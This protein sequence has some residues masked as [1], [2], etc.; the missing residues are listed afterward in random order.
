MTHLLTATDITIERL[1]EHTRE[2]AI[3]LTEINEEALKALLSLVHALLTVGLRFLLFLL[4]WRLNLGGIS[5]VSQE[6][7][8]L[9]RHNLLDEFVLVD[10]FEVTV[11]ILQERSDFIV[12]DI[13]LHNLIHHLIELLLTDFLCRWNGRF[14]EFLTD[15]LLDITNLVFLL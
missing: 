11:D 1:H 15:N 6:L 3:L 8:K 9:Q 2:E 13:G 7:T 12:V 5:V 14:Y 10:K 4:S